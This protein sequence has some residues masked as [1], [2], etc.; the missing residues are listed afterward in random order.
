MSSPFKNNSQKMHLSSV[1]LSAPGLVMWPHS[2]TGG[3][4]NCSLILD[5]YLKFKGSVTKEE[6]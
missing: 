2:T 1:Y 6:G 5:N 3:I 4:G